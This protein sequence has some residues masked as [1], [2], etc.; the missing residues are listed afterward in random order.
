MQPYTCDTTKESNTDALYSLAL[1]LVT[2]RNYKSMQVGKIHTS[3]NKSNNNN[4]NNNN[5]SI[6]H[7]PR[8]GMQG[9]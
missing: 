1:M 7:S 2:K 8:K 9:H 6:E 5:N 4:N 3:Y